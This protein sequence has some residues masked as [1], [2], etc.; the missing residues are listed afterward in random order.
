[1]VAWAKA[2]RPTELGGLG[3]TDLRLAGFALQTRWLWLQRTDNSRAWS[4]LPI[5]TD[6]EVQAFFRASMFSLVGDGNTTK[7][8]DDR[9]V[10]GSTP[11]DIAPIVAAMVPTRTRNRLTVRQGLTTRRWTRSFSG[12]MTPATIIEYLE[13]WD[14]VEQVNLNDQPDKMVWRW[15]PDGAYTAQSAY[16]RLHTGSIPFRAMQ[17]SGKHGLLC[18]SKPS[19]GLH[20]GTTIGRTTVE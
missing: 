2:C 9:W 11:S 17:S 4:E 7:F 20:S 16:A 1:M 15:T 6:P 3:I 12:Y 8:W 5:K 19:F 10:D 14:A 18:T 13:L